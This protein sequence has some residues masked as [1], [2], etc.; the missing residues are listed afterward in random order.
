MNKVMFYD[1]NDFMI[2]E[3]DAKIK[4]LIEWAERYNEVGCLSEELKKPNNCSTFEL[5]FD[6]LLDFTQER[7]ETDLQIDLNE[8]KAQTYL[9]D[10]WENDRHNTIIDCYDNF[11]QGDVDY[12]VGRNNLFYDIILNDKKFLKYVR[13]EM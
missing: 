1:C 5:I 12:T 6:T 4:D 10:L 2:F 11:K 9:K 7:I 13:E 8:L 3:T